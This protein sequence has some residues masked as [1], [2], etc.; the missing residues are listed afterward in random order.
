[1]VREDILGGLR[2]ALQRGDSL[3]DAIMPFFNAGY[4]IDEV[5]DAVKALEEEKKSQ[6]Q[7]AEPALFVPQEVAS[8]TEELE[9]NE[10]IPEEKAIKIA[11]VPKKP[12]PV[13]I[14]KV[15]AYGEKH[16]KF[17]P[18]LKKQIQQP[19]QQPV[20][21]QVVVQKVSG[22]GEAPK[23]GGKAVIYILIA[24]LIILIGLLA[25]VFF[26]KNEIIGLFTSGG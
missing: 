17:L 23:P 25:T 24:M 8:R 7:P 16:L 1:M 15:S 3:K 21:Q 22:Y 9:T 19:V 26:F 6:G 11:P 13:V 2:I 4:K 12:A 5:E 10:P 20:Q 18:K 14:Q